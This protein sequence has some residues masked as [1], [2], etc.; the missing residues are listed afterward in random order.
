[1]LWGGGCGGVGGGGGERG[2]FCAVDFKRVRSK[3]S[4]S[5]TYYFFT[6]R[7]LRIKLVGLHLVTG[8]FVGIEITAVA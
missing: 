1:M 8:G 2:W 7:H 4:V 6:I 3:S 5:W